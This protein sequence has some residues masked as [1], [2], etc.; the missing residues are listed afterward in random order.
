MPI[1]RLGLSGI[2]RQLYGSFAGK[3]ETVEGITRL[4]LS[5]ISR[6]R[7][8]S[9]AGKEAAIITPTGANKYIGFIND[10]GRGMNF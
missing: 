4:G 10:V 9:F 2:P 1:T 5:G 6:Q 3:E 7:Y 8:G